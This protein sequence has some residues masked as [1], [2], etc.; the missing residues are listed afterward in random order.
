MHFAKY[1]FTLKDAIVQKGCVFHL[2]FNDVRCKIKRL[3]K[4][5]GIERNLDT[6]LRGNVFTPG[7]KAASKK[8]HEF[9]NKSIRKIVAAKGK[10][11]LSGL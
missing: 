11:Q 6:T 2:T 3:S 5:S 10:S 9:T 4:K 8:N 1:A 7:S